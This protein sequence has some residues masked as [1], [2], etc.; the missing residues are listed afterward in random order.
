MTARPKPDAGRFAA[1]YDRVMAPLERMGLHRLR[2]R[3]L[4]QATGRILEIG[5]GTGATLPFYGSTGCLLGLDANADMLAGS[6]ARAR[7]LGRCLRLSQASSEKLPFRDGA[8]DT[9][10]GTLVLCSVVDPIQSLQEI[11]RVLRRPGGQLLLLEHT[12]PDAP[13]FARLVDLANGPW[14]ALNGQCHINRRTADAVAE[15]GFRVT[16]IERHVG[17]LVRLIAAGIDG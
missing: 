14:L 10:V 1:G 11:R 8:F 5:I 13:L 2:R 7:A 3:L 12:R 17:G 4:P 15:A 16:A 9:V 6:A